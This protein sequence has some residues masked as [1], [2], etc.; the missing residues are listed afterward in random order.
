MIK[1]AFIFLIRI[2]QVVLRPIFPSSCVFHAGGS[3]GCS[4][5]TI[6][7]IRKY[8]PLKGVLLGIH[9]ILRCHPWQKN[10]YDPVP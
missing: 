2:Y 8:G 9:R 5:Y 1:K 7:V 6:A 10:T 4:D 3:P